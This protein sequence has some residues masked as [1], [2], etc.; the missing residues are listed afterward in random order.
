MSD[1]LAVAVVSAALRRLVMGAVQADVPGAQVTT[2]R[3]AEPGITSGIPDVGVNLYLYE[4]A[5]VAALRNSALPARRVDGSVMQRPAAALELHY[6]F[7]FY[8]NEGALEPQRLM[9]STIARLTAEPLLTRTRVEDTLADPL[10]P[11]LANSDL[12]DQIDSVK[13]TPLSLS[14][15]EMSRIWSVFFQTRYTLSMAWRASAIFIEPQ[16]RVAPSLPVRESLLL[17][18]PIR[19]PRITDVVA[20]AGEDAPIVP[21]ADIVI[22]GERLRAD[23]LEILVGGNL[24]APDF[25]SDERIDLAL[26]AGLPAGPQSVQVRHLLPLGDPPVPHHGFDSN[27]GAFILHPL[28]AQAGGNYQIAVT[29]VTGTGGNPRSAT[30]TPTLTSSAGPSQQITLELLDTATATVVRTFFAAPLAA[31]TTTPSFPVTNIPAGTYL[32]R[33]RINGADSALDR[34][35]NPGSPTFGQAIAPTLTI[36]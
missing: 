24:A 8:G 21:G 27:P 20:A 28:I 14:L 32:A 10:T 3:P 4:T 34:D 26:P 5:P 33:V 15:E 1:F 25:A 6:L 30:I 35:T 9:G 12:G 23:L 16:L 36:P 31:D 17:A 2:L 19:Q 29:N 7:S 18:V 11:F 13:F 22:R